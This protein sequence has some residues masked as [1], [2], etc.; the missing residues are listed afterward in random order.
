MRPLA[1]QIESV[2]GRDVAHDLMAIEIEFAVLRLLFR[3]EVSRL[4]LSI[5]HP[6][7]DAEKDRDDWHDREYSVVKLQGRDEG[8]GGFAPSP[9]S[10]S[11]CLEVRSAV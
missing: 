6:D 2:P 5:V 9:T 11:L 4:V 3:V 7:H 10:R 8:P 1:N